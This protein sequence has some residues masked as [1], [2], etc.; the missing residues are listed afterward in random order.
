MSK[1]IVHLYTLTY[2]EEKILPFFFQHYEKFVDRFYVFDNYSTD[3]T[4]E[5]CK[6]RKDV[7]FRRWDSKGKMD[8]FQLTEMRN[9]IWKKS[10]T[11]CDFVLVVDADEFLYH[12]NMKSV[13]S[14]MKKN[15]CTVAK[16]VGFGML[17]SKFPV[18]NILIT[19]QIKKGI[20]TPMMDKCVLFDPKQ[21]LNMS[22]G[23]GSHNCLPE[24]YVR[25]YRDENLK[26][27]HY[28]ALGIDYSLE[29]KQLF[30]KRVPKKNLKM[31]ISKHY[32]ADDNEFVKAVNNSIKKAKT[33]I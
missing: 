8:S 22:F 6:K 29:R 16:P 23:L 25:V 31:G 3:R 15:I 5:I 20:R 7:I 10:I 30:R 2:N 27:L 4:E 18:D 11:P 33:V 17:S 26:L 12:K 1:P 32:F 13:L 21:I 9:K 24:G 14:K 28:K 19:E